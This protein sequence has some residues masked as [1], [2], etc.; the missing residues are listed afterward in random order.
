M[1]FDDTVVSCYPCLKKKTCVK[2]ERKGLCPHCKHYGFM[3]MQ[4]VNKWNF[5][6]D[7]DGTLFTEDPS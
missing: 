5:G 7:T 2:S 3:I 1:A 6:D 4:I